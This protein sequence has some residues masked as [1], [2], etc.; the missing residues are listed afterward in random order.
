MRSGLFGSKNVGEK[1]KQSLINYMKVIL[2]VAYEPS[3]IEHRSIIINTI[4]DMEIGMSSYPNG[5]FSNKCHKTD[6]PDVR[7]LADI[8]EA[9]NL[10]FRVVFINALDILLSTAVRR[11]FGH[12]E[13]LDKMYEHVTEKYI[14]QEQLKRLDTRFYKCFDDD[15]LPALPE[16]F[17]VFLNL[18][19]EGGDEFQVKNYKV[20]V[21]EDSRKKLRKRFSK[22]DTNGLYKNLQKSIDKIEQICYD[23]GTRY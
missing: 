12:W 23:A 3:D 16:G 17:G 21:N 5:H 2:G 7:V 11:K 14:I 18:N 22:K 4:C 13:E 15:K 9:L 20:S 1:R 19:S 8:F 10:D 6:F